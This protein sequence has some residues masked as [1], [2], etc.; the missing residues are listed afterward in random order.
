MNHTAPRV[1]LNIGAPIAHLALVNPPLNVID[2]AMM[3]ELA[4]ALSEIEPRTDISAIV[5]RGA[6]K[7][8]SA[9]VDVAAHAPDLVE[10]M[11]GKFHV[12]I[13]ALVSS[14]KIT[15]AVVHGNCLG[16]GAELAMACDLVYSS[17]DAVWG[18]PEI[19]LGCFPP[20]A[21]T[22]LGSLVSPKRAAELILTGK[23]ISGAEAFEIGLTTR[24]VVS[25]EIDATVDEVLE[26]IRSLSPAALA[27]TKKAVYAWDAMHFD[28]GL[29]RAEKIYLD[30]LMRTEDA[31]EG[32]R[33][34]LEKRPPQ[35]K[36]R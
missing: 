31:Q 14:K 34:F 3:D 21:V 1:I 2:I 20:V 4:S 33:A 26:R 15:I 9:G 11:L 32:I 25:D 19:Q 35:W 29:A 24:A 6:G 13:R 8:F 36:N 23:T 7:C 18:F 12:V 27:L 22:A 28:K 5:I 30:E 17:N 10:E 16:G